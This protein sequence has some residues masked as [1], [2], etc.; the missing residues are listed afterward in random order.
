MPKK[1]TTHTPGATHL[2][3]FSVRRSTNGRRSGV[4][5][6]GAALSSRDMTRDSAPSSKAAASTSRNASP[7]TAS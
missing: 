2:R 1:A 5:E 4:K 6:I 7:E 3:G